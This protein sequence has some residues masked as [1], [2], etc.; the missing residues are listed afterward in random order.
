MSF[1]EELLKSLLADSV[2]GRQVEILDETVSTN[3]H[4]LRLAFAGAQ[5]GT[6]VLADCQTGGKGRLG[7]SWFSPAGKNIYTT[8]ILRPEIDPALSPQ[9]T[10]IAGVAVAELL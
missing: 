2:F 1:D 5:E 10:I 4:A 7:R 9:I 3:N 8:V 6:A